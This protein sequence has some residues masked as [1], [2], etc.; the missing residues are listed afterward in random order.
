MHDTFDIFLAVIAAVGLGV[1]FGM[2]L[3]SPRTS[4]PMRVQQATAHAQGHPKP[5]LVVVAQGRAVAQDKR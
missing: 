5:E 1:F 3:G 4:R 2:P